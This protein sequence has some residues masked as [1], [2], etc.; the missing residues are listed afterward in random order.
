MRML[1]AVCVLGIAILL[2]TVFSFIR[3]PSLPSLASA[4]YHDP[5]LPIDDR[6]EDVLSR[7]SLDEKIGQMALV[8]KNSIQDPEDIPRYGLG[9]ILS[10]AGGKPEDNTPE[11]WRIMTDSF[12][13]L[14]RTSRTGIPILYG[15][16]ANHGHGNVPGAT[17]FPHAIG[18]GAADNAAL[19]ARIAQI[20]AEE[21]RAT[22]ANWI[23]GP[24]LDLP[25]DIR[26]GRVYESFSDDPD[27]AGRLGAAFVRGF[28]EGGAIAT[29][30]HFIGVGSMQWGTSIHENFS[31]DQ[32]MTLPNEGALHASYL[33]PFAQAVDAGAESV[34]VGLNMW[35][36]TDMAANRY[37]ISD[38]LKGELGFKGFV[39]SDWYGVYEIS[40]DEYYSAVT[41]I[42]AGVDMVMLPFNYKGFTRDVRNA[43]ARGEIS[44]ERIN[45]AVRRILRVKFA[46]GLFDEPD[47]PLLSIVGSS[48]HRALAREAAARS[49]VV[50]KND[51][52]LPLTFDLQKIRV[53]G[54]AADNIGRQSG[55]WTVE[56][57]GIDGNW[58]PDA[59]SILQGLREYAGENVQYAEDG[60]FAE[61]DIAE[62]GIAF[63]GE[64]PYAEGWGDNPEPRLSDEDLRA[65]DNLSKSVRSV[66]VVIVSGRPL[67]ITD[68]ISKWD[69]L[70]AAWLPGSEGDGVADA[71]YGII[72]TGTLPLS[73][74]RGMSDIPLTEENSSAPLFP[75]GFGLRI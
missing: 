14:S 28:R 58:L 41:A 20:T 2:L 3:T 34:M 39:V 40:H 9:A 48:A 73:W 12:V 30:K 10:G 35:G 37:L 45:D 46:H 27:R 8:E 4:R 26:W 42:N 50:L 24:S 56:W 75:R 15:L 36:E 55:A 38:V 25:T 18:I 43:V 69:G 62:I 74:P 68:E 7:M 65:I 21:V 57:Q 23:Y 66:I 60:V 47:M 44:E 29:P 1:P 22:G 53:A 71:L 52:V 31:I 67:L 16:D 61:N 49:A 5:E 64:K 13:A 33:P 54:S 63:V 11:G 70:V 6:I 19:A 51:G 59:T 32:G 17:I 72:P